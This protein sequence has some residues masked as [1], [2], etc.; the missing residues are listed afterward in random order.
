MDLPTVAPL[1]FLSRCLVNGKCT[2]PFFAVL[3]FYNCITNTSAASFTSL[4]P[5]LFDSE[6]TR[7]N[8]SYAADVS[9][10]GEYVVGT[11][12]TP[13]RSF[14]S[15]LWSRSTGVRFIPDLPP[16]R[17]YS[18]IPTP[19]DVADDGTTLMAVNSSETHAQNYLWGLDTGAIEIGNRNSRAYAITPDGQMV[20]GAVSDPAYWTSD[21]DWKILGD[22]PIADSHHP[23]MTGTALAVSTGGS[24][25]VGYADYRSS[26]SP[27]LYTAFRWTSAD[28]M[29]DLGLPAEYRTARATAVSADGSIVAGSMEGRVFR[30]TR[31]SGVQLFARDGAGYPVMSDDGARIVW[32]GAPYPTPKVWSQRDGIKSLQTMLIDAGANL[33]GWN[34][35]SVT[36]ISADGRTI[37]GDA[38]NAIGRTHAYVA[39]LPIPEPPS[40][41]LACLFL[42]ALRNLM[43]RAKRR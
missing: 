21:Q 23:R 27:E 32:N 26:Q 1:R 8:D 14:L 18:D 10:N 6:A 35:I 36:G 42:S 28:G 43:S 40:I 4:G 29:H 5:M 31:E 41:I 9:S 15:F 25:L 24:T 34:I 20:V 12:S 11:W 16:S 37:V 38:R 2:G 39:T 22:L 33:D 3:F 30:W 13:Q 19:H 7:V 17:P